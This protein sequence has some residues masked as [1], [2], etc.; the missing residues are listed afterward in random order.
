MPSFQQ[1]LWSPGSVP[2]HARRTC[3][4]ETWLPLGFGGSSVA[5]PCIHPASPVSPLCSQGGAVPVISEPLT[6]ELLLSSC[7]SVFDSTNIL[8]CRGR[9]HSAPPDGLYVM[10][11]F[12]DTK[13]SDPRA[14]CRAAN[15]VL[16]VGLAQGA[17]PSPPGAQWTQLICGAA[18]WGK[19]DWL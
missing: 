19:A 4:R 14:T 10:L 5:P 3:S 2:W 17:Q 1:H 7:L 16:D 12:C 6:G 8:S 15:L 11:P 13:S 18:S 9:V